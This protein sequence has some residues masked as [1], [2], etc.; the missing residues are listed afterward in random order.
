MESIVVVAAG[1]LLAGFGLVLRR[2]TRRPPAP[3]AR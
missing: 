3:V 2:L 1:G